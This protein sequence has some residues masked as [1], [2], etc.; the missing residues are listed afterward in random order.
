[1]RARIAGVLLQ[2]PPG[3]LRQRF[4]ALVVGHVLAGVEGELA[5]H[6]QLIEIRLHRRRDAPPA[7][8]LAAG[9]SA[10][11][12]ARPALVRDQGGEDL[13]RRDVAEVQV[14]RHPAGRV[15]VRMVVILGVAP[16][17][18]ASTNAVEPPLR[19]AR[20]PG[21]RHRRDVVIDWERRENAAIAARASRRRPAASASR[22]RRAGARGAAR[23]RSG[24]SGAR[25][26]NRRD[27]RATCAA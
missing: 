16:R 21:H 24:A 4:P 14:R 12:A 6:E 10:E 9:A 25:P 11:P 13:V 2:R 23:R 27:D 18:A 8:A 7:L 20:P 22:S 26:G 5:P 3:P 1:M 15:A 17:P 19:R